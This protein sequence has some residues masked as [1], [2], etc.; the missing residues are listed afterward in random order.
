[1]SDAAGATHEPPSEAGWEPQVFRDVVGRFASGVTVITAH[2]DGADFG[3]TASAMCSLSLEPPMV[4][5]C[6]NRRAVTRAAVSNSRA[7]AVNIL[8]EDQ[9]ELAVRFAT[10]QPDKFAGLTY[11]RGELGC[12]RLDGVLAWLECEVVEDVEGGTH[13]VFFGRVRTAE[14][15]EGDPLAYFRGQFGRLYS[16]QDDPI[17]ASLREHVL[18]T[19]LEDGPLDLQRLSDDLRVQRSDLDRSIARLMSEGVVAHD[20]ELGYVLAPIDER[21]IDRT[22]DARCAMELGAVE[23]A[24]A[25]ELDVALVTK[26]RDDMT[27]TRL[28]VR[29]G[30]LTDVREYAAA[31]ARFHETLVKLAGSPPLLDAYRRLSL[32]GILIRALTPSG[33]ATEELIDDHQALVEAIEQA[34]LP[35]A[36]AA[37]QLHTEHTKEVHRRAA[38]G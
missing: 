22:F 37:I 27:R 6:V 4:L 13:S 34:D 33:F 32:P 29:D 19:A 36:R 28:L 12:T 5:V 8:Q 18:G 25:S 31:N 9:A 26:L 11:T 35:A 21:T 23:V 30:R 1:M 38:A 20:R 15:R 16:N 14:G 17:A 2:D 3:M 7:F 10:P 24:L